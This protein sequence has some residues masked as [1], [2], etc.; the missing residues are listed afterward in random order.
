MVHSN[1]I[2]II[3]NIMIFFM[4]LLMAYKSLVSSMSHGHYQLC[5]CLIFVR[6]GR[7]LNDKWPYIWRGSLYGRET[8][9]R[10]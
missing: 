6:V 7:L 3:L 1:I 10:M 5:M 8:R 2:I 4:F 9:S